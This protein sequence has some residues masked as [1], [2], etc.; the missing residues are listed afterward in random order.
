MWPH[1]CSG[2]RRARPPA[3]LGGLTSFGAAPR[4]PARPRRHPPALRQVPPA[5]PH[6]RRLVCCALHRLARLPAAQQ[7]RMQ[8]SSSKVL[9]R[10]SMHCYVTCVF[11]LHATLPGPRP[12][13]AILHVIPLGVL[14]TV[15]WRRCNCNVCGRSPKVT[16]GNYVRVLPG[17]PL[18]LPAG[19]VISHAI[20]FWVFQTL[21][22]Y[23]WNC[24]VSGLC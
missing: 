4:S 22:L 11:E 24:N 5:P 16:A 19:T 23:R 1:G 15:N 6:R 12:R 14:Q 17:L 20:P 21:N 18:P 8:F 13:P 9:V 7:F 10:V 2:R 3:R